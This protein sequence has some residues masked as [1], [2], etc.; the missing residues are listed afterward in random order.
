M[1]LRLLGRTSRTSRT[2]PTSRSSFSNVR[3]H[4]TRTNTALALSA[5]I[6]VDKFAPILIKADS[7]F[8]PSHPAPNPSNASLFAS[9]VHVIKKL[10]RILRI[11]TQNDD[12]HILKE[13]LLSGGLNLDSGLR[14]VSI[15]THLLTNVIH[16]SAIKGNIEILDFLIQNG[17]SID[18]WYGNDKEFSFCRDQ[19]VEIHQDERGPTPLIFSIMLQNLEIMEMLI[20]NGADVDRQ[21]HLCPNDTDD[22]H[23]HYLFVSPLHY[24]AIHGDARFVKLLINQGAFIDPM[25]GFGETPLF[26]AVW[27]EHEDVVKL[28]LEGGADP[29]IRNGWDRCISDFTKNKRIRGMLGSV[30]RE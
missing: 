4:A 12:I 15:R 2:S 9:D 20:K 16:I 21:C 22:G 7:D 30:V 19:I 28:L 3:C 11:A 13:I 14:G 8:G 5:K 6:L 24:A 10:N 17:S 1:L 18:E 25:N 26:H 29:W 27:Q 23:E